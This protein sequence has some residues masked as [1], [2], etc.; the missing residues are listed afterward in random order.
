MQLIFPTNQIC[1]GKVIHALPRLAGCVLIQLVLPTPG[2][3]PPARVFCFSKTRMRE[4]APSELRSNSM[5]VKALFR[6]SHNWGIGCTR[7]VA[8]FVRERN[9]REETRQIPHLTPFVRYL[10]VRKKLSRNTT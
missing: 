1:S 2:R 3:V 7:N 5:N 4:R 10:G 9:G 6:L 8:V